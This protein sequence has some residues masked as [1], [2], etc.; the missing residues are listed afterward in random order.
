MVVGG[1]LG[2]ENMM[3]EDFKQTVHMH[4]VQELTYIAYQASQANP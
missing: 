2:T 1:L 3:S 4:Y